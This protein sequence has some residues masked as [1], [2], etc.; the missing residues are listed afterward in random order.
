MSSRPDPHMSCLDFAMKQNSLLIVGTENC[1]G[2][3]S[4]PLAGLTFFPLLNN[5]NFNGFVFLIQSLNIYD[6]KS[7]LC[8]PTDK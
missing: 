3:G 6:D 4:P 7:S 1:C 2:S 5:N 8:R